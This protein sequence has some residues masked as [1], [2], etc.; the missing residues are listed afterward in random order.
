MQKKRFYVSGIVV[1]WLA[2]LFNLSVPAYTQTSNDILF[3]NTTQ[4]FFEVT[5]VDTFKNQWQMT[6]LGA[7]LKDPIMEP[8]LEEAKKQIDA[9]WV[10]RLGLTLNDL[11]ALPTGPI[12]GGMIA[13]PGA[14]PGFILVISVKGKTDETLDF[15]ERISKKLEDQG[16]KKATTIIENVTA[17][18]FTFEKTE[19]DP[20][21]G[22][23]VYLLTRDTLVITDRIHLAAMM[24]KRLNGDLTAPLRNKPAYK[25]VMDRVTRDALANNS[26]PLVRWY[27]EPLEFTAAMR[28]ISGDNVPKKKGL[29][30]VDAYE[31]LAAHGF[32]NIL[33]VGGILDLATDNNQLAY[34]I[35]AFAPQPHTGAALKMLSFKNNTDFVPPKWLPQDAA[36]FTILYADPQVIFE[37]IGPI[38]DDIVDEPGVWDAV[39]EGF[40]EDKFRKPIDIQKELVDLLGDKLIF[41]TRFEKPITP[42][43]S[44]FVAALALKPGKDAE[45][46]QAFEKLFSDGQDAKKTERNGFIYWQSLPEGDARQP[47]S[48][49]T[50]RTTRDRQSV[51]PRTNTPPRTTTPPRTG[52]SSTPNLPVGDVGKESGAVVRELFFDKGGLVVG[53]G[54]I[55]ISN[56]LADLYAILDATTETSFET[57]KDY[58]AVTQKLE[59]LDAGKGERFMQIVASSGELIMPTYELAREGKVPESQTI[60]GAILR[61]IIARNEGQR[62]TD[63]FDRSTLPPFEQIE[64]Y[65][66][67]AGSVATVETDGWLIEGV[68]LP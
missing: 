46:V 27:I 38:F 4:G 25:A 5:S 30:Q 67:T 7:L 15:M 28:M 20:E 49:G 23:A 36:R 29:V 8:A 9:K 45:V 37:N 17:T 21:G 26:L 6:R 48:T 3:P 51:V 33:G 62:M 61:A 60:L 42:D 57:S 13:V 41:M 54:H 14:M 34:R 22:I 63:D 40:R 55:F 1:F 19:N 11:Q 2:L 66:G 59:Q 35:K 16:V 47:A 64:S 24:V 10:N 18:H 52:T 32:K 39:I 65:F 43:S 68:Q 53:K 50:M 56:D 31:L 58:L 44:R 12:S